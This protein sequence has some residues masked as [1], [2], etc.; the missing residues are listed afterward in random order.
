M[1][2]EIQCD[3][4]APEHQI[5]RFNSG[6]NT[7]LGSAGG[8]NAIG[9]STFLW[10]IDYVFGGESYYSLTDDIKKEIGPHTIYFT[11][12]FEGQPYYFYR[13]TDDPKSVY[14]I[15]KERHFITKLTLDEFRRFLFQEY[16]IGLPALTFSE[17]TERFFRIYGREN[18]LEKYPLLVKPR[19]QDEKAVDFL[20]KLFGHYKILASIKFMEEELG[21]KASQLKSRQRQKVD[22][23]K[24]ESN[25]KTIESLRKRLQK[26]MKNSEEA[27]LAM[28][29][30]DTQTFERIT[31]V[32]K[33]LN[34]I[35]R[36]RNRLQSQL[37]AIKS[38]ITDSKA[39]TASE[40]ESL[41][42]FF[43]NANLKAFEEIEH[44]H[45]KIREIL[46]EEMD[47]EIYRLQPLIEEYDK[48]IRRLNRKIEESGIAKEMSERVLS[49]CVNVSKSIDRLEEE[50][51]ELIHQKELQDA[52]AEAEQKL[53]KLLLQQTEKLGEI[54]DDINLRMETI[55]G[56]VT[57]KQE[58]APLLYITP[59]K[60][61]IFETPGNTSEGTAFKSLV[62][63]DLS[64]L[65]LRP[66]P[67]IIHDS[68]ILK[69]IED[70]HLE[71]I[72]ER[73]QSTKH[74]VFIAFDKADSTTEKAHRI[75]EETAILRLSDGNELF[76]RSWS[77]YETND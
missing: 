18:T 72:L 3:K 55:N 58:T 67:A 30:F 56:V 11:F 23:D 10:I 25:Q 27:Q 54:Q 77:K 14:R 66:I 57:D 76:G 19:E 75:L 31:A 4:F 74:Q 43:P 68:N 12:E 1:L 47:Q 42:R 22:I 69:R 65:E 44:F 51:A 13:S 52:R 34:S 33:E 2:I 32:Q 48:E 24:I 7:V 63:Y 28:F 70:V 60:D 39:E 5:I 40:F 17:I 62:V 20:L 8:S 26:L 6:L 41:L 50:T 53:E 64:V 16:K 45:I 73:Y 29:G 71:H 9:K 37:N 59:Q 61:I 35:I 46:G 49:Q 21:I 38:N 36:K 15:D